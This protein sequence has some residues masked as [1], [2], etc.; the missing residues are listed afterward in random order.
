MKAMKASL[1][2]ILSCLACA[3]ANARPAVLTTPL[4]LRAEQRGGLR[5]QFAQARAD[6]P[7]PFEAVARVRAGIVRAD[8]VKRGRIAPVSPMLKT[9]GPAGLWPM[10]ELLAQGDPTTAELTESQWRA[11]AVGLLE[12][13]GAL[14]DPRA[15]PVIVA[16]LEGPDTDFSVVQ[17]AAGALGKL[18]SDAAAQRLVALSKVE[19]PKRQAVLAG[20][21]DCRRKLTV[22]ALVAA[23][24]ARPGEEEAERIVDALGSAGSA[25]AWQTPGAG[26]AEEQA[27]VREAAARALVGA[28]TGLEGRVPQAASNALMVVD[29]PG[30]P[31]MI[32]EARKGAGERLAGE[33]DGL[34]A[35]FARNPSR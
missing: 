24:A 9:L 13:V 28:F 19:G 8:A 22:D 15:E 23:L 26:L 21:G 30:T 2:T 18:G 16:V 4:E 25:W 11:L 3:S 14:R 35:R 7:K 27:A 34:A 6:D 17:A 20:M 1:M 33:L 32:A 31:A 5:A 12:A 10:L 29:W